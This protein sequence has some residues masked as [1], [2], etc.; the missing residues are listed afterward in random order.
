[1]GADHKRA[2]GFLRGN[3]FMKF[4]TFYFKVTEIK[5]AVAFWE[6][7]LQVKPHKTSDNWYEF[8]AGDV[9]FGLLYSEE[10]TI[11]GCNGAPVFELQDNQI[12]PAIDRALLL[13]A[14]IVVDGLDD[15][16]MKSI[17]MAD[18]CGN[19]FEFTRYHD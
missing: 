17:V 14:S 16:H 7:I 6:G 10:M 4:R 19:E 15:P 11:T 13:G 5:K 3:Y 12:K 1:M 9:R 2:D 18:P 8:M